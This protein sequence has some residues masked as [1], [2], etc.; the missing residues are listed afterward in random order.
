M[1]S[2][3]LSLFPTFYFII[4]QIP[5]Y[6]FGRLARGIC[7]IFSETVVLL[8]IFTKKFEEKR[9]KRNYWFQHIKNIEHEDSN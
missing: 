6:L 5:S 7:K 9:K 3:F 4:I 1:F 2:R 8:I